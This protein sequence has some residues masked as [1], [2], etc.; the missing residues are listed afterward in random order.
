MNFILTYNHG[1]RRIFV[2]HIFDAHTWAWRHNG[3]EGSRL[4]T[5]IEGRL[6][7]NINVKKWVQQS[8]TLEES[9]TNVVLK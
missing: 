7:Q 4:S 9:V 8:I 5:E 6:E 2:A 3:A 1:F